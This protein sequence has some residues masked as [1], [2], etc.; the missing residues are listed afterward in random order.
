MTPD[1][2][3][4]PDRVLLRLEHLMTEITTHPD[5]TARTDTPATPAT[6]ATATG[7]PVVVAMHPQA[8]HQRA[9]GLLALRRRSVVLVGTAA[10]VL[11]AAGVGAVGLAGSP[12][13]GTPAF[14]VTPDRGDVVIRIVDTTAD[15]EQMTAQLAAEGLDIQVQTMTANPQVVGSWVGV[16]A[17]DTTDETVVADVIEQAL[18]YPED[19]RVPADVTGLTLVVGVPAELGDEPAVIGL[20][21][22][23]AP[24]QPLACS[25][26]RG[27]TLEEATAILEQQG[28]QPRTVAIGSLRPVQAEAS[29]IVTI[30]YQA[31]DAPD[32]V[33]LVTNAPD[34]PNLQGQL[35]YGF[36]PAAVADGACA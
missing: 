35:E 1:P 32:E 33:M 21:N 24:G 31:D 36:S 14:A 7:E 5:T 13:L 6:A 29:D 9:P 8:R 28:L 2:R 15:A 27:A 22:A 10:A 17:E 19:V 34:A 25:P 4:P 23:F 26:A 30:A 12:G 11:I 18:G 20:R 3:L 16:S